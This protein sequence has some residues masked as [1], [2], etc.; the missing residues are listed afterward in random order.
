MYDANRPTAIQDLKDTLTPL[1]GKPFSLLLKLIR[2]IRVR[3]LTFKPE[4]KQE[5][6]QKKFKKKTFL[7]FTLCCIRNWTIYT[8]TAYY[9]RGLSEELECETMKNTKIVWKTTNIIWSLLSNI[10]NSSIIGSSSF[11][12]ALGG[13]LSFEGP[14]RTSFCIPLYKYKGICIYIHTTYIS[15]CICMCIVVWIV[16][17]FYSVCCYCG[18]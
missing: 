6:M 1:V 13:G 4:S 14:E 5:R 9:H 17:F 2:N 11:W 7:R 8:Y 10:K 16:N 15:Q 18:I 12:R 3:C